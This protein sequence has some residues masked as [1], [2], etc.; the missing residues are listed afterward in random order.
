MGDAA[1]RPWARVARG[2]GIAALAGIA[3]IGLAQANFL[4]FHT[5]VET[6]SVVVAFTIF[7]VAWNSRHF[8]DGHFFPWIG[9]A[10]LVVGTLDLLHAFSYKGIGLLGD[11]G[12]NLPTQLWVTA[13]YVEA[14]SWLLAILLERRQRLSHAHA[15]GYGAAL[16]TG[17]AVA[18]G[19]DLVPDCYVEGQGMTGFK[20]ASEYAVIALKVVTA[21]L[22][23]RSGLHPRV[24]VLLVASLATGGAAEVAF[25]GY[26]DV[27]DSANQVGHLLKVAAFFLIYRATVETGLVEPYKLLFRRLQAAHDGLEVTVADRTRELA[28]ANEALAESNARLDALIKAS[29]L[30]II[31][32]DADRRVTLWNKSAERMFGVLAAGKL[33]RPLRPDVEANLGA[34][35]A[36]AY[37]GECVEGLETTLPRTG[38]GEAHVRVYCAP[39]L[40]ADGTIA[41]VVTVNADIGGELAARQSLLD[42]ERRLSGILSSVSDAII[43]I[44]ERGL[45]QSF[46][47]AAEAVFGYGASEVIGRNVSILMQP[48]DAALHDSYVRRYV[49]TGSGRFLGAG[50]REFTA[51]H[52]DGHEVLIDLQVN[53]TVTAEG[54]LFI[55]VARDISARRRAAA[56]KQALERE[57]AQAHKMEALG[58]LA[59]GIAHEVNN[60][61]VPIIGLADLTLRR[62]PPDL[63]ANLGK[64][65]TAAERARDIVGRVLTFSRTEIPSRRPLHLGEALREAVRLLSVAL[66]AAIDIRCRLDADPVVLA[67]ATEVQQVILNLA[68]NAAHA[69]GPQGGVLDVGLRLED[70]ASGGGPSR[71]AV[72]TVADNGSGM[73]ERTLSKIFEPF[74]TTK[75]VG[76]GTGMGLSVVHGIVSKWGGAIAV[77][78]RIGHG[79]TFTIRLPLHEVATAGDAA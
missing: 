30:A 69:M 15:L 70:T 22:V 42:S 19:F 12:A 38:G 64:I 27:Y 4:L 76:K 28:R 48:A 53:E 45:I 17:I 7:V 52:K 13:R 78:S 5:L 40:E 20:L 74:F 33:G 50:P 18:F 57:L 26:L 68:T 11:G 73:D 1:V 10:Y 43:T 31:A 29:P 72:V 49:E 3:L 77:E 23:L 9:I 75:A 61:L 25:S 21:G 24:R 16:A 6:F 58:N 60:M 46:N 54:R 56:D 47:P 67:D 51:R 71:Q 34:M 8:S 62:A 55:G 66:P 59:G 2:A 41:G 65:L 39:L 36:S 14:V 44:D 63:H 35:L 37:S 79:S 32:L